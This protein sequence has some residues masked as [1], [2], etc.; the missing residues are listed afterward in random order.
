MKKL[1]KIDKKCYRFLADY[2]ESDHISCTE[3][4][5]YLSDKKFNKWYR[6]KYLKSNANIYF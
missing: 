5:K 6:K 3:I 4:I 1:F 2:V